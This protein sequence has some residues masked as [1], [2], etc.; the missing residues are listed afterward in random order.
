VFPL[1]ARAGV[2]PGHLLAAMRDWQRFHGD[3]TG[4]ARAGKTHHYC[5]DW[6]AG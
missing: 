5:P 6:Q 2:Q 4:R 3:A 1:K